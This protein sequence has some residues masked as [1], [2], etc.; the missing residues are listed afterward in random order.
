MIQSPLD[1]L[2]WSDWFPLIGSWR[3]P[4]VPDTAGLYR[5]RRLGLAGLDYIGQTGSGRM[6]LRRRLAMLSGVYSPNM[7]YRAPHTAGPA[8]W[9]LRASSCCEFEVSVINLLGADT[10]RK[11]MEALALS[12]YR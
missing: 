7:P 6:T 11:G 9:A 2:Q 8:L 12:L 10:W 3:D 4:H 1:L 5:I